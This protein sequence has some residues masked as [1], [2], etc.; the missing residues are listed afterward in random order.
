MSTRETELLA[1]QNYQLPNYKRVQV[2]LLR[3][4]YIGARRREAGEV[5]K[6]DEPLAL[7]LIAL[8]RA[9]PIA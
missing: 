8:K 9:E 6:V 1:A 2:R 7:D 5:V 3:A 4:L